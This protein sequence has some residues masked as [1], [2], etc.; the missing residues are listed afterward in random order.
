MIVCYDDRL[1]STSQRSKANG[2][3]L[4]VLKTVALDPSKGTDAKFG[5]YS[6]F[7]ML[8]IGHDGTLYVDAE[9]GLRNTADLVDT[10]LAIHRRFGPDVFGVETNQFQELLADELKRRSAQQKLLLPVCGIRNQV[11]KQVRIR[12]LTPFLAQGR[13]RFKGDSP[14]ARLLVD[15]LRDFPLADHDD[16][17][18]V[19]EMAVR[20]AGA[21]L[22]ATP[23]EPPVEY[24]IA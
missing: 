14:G 24:V 11:N 18:D 8:L 13:L 21:L 7:A 5:D 1:P 10:A 16:G 12:K 2:A 20:L 15:Q 6:A 17:P 4:H 23:E 3:T 19:L 9:L 22:A